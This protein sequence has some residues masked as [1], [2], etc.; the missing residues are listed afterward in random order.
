MSG[1]A[2]KAEPV[3]VE[4][5]WVSVGE[6]Q[7]SSGKLAGAWAKI[8]GDTVS[9]DVRLFDGRGFK[10]FAG[11]VHKVKVEHQGDRAVV[12]GGIGEYVRRWEDMKACA[13]WEALESAA[14]IAH[15]RALE[16]KKDRA[17]DNLAEL[18]KPVIRAYAKGDTLGRKVILLDV[19][20]T[21][22]VGAA[23]L[24]RFG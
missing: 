17:V 2:K 14:K 6:R 10:R 9:D 22:Q 4:E 15:R 18:L 3:T 23:K 24:G 12:H 13:Q 1:A 5:L 16:Q 11:A 8:D 20:E 7:L 21:I 19:L